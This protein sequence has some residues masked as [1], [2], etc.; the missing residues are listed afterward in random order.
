MRREK[1]QI[2]GE[3]V[4]GWEGLRRKETALANENSNVDLVVSGDLV[5]LGGELI[6]LVLVEGAEL[7]AIV[8]GDD[9]DAAL[10][11]DADDGGRHSGGM[12]G[13]VERVGFLKRRLQVC[14]VAESQGEAGGELEW[15]GD[16]SRDG[17]KQA[18]YRKRADR[19]KREKKG[20]RAV[21]RYLTAKGNK[22][23]ACL[24]NPR[25][26]KRK[27]GGGRGKGGMGC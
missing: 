10:V 24:R 21:S 16:E 2:W 14:R 6:V 23:E 8:D 12:C 7:L 11:L 15:E 22:Q 20:G 13:I 19:E 1:R 5:H 25:K 26:R 27:R 9:G 17:A 4:K 3:G 18:S